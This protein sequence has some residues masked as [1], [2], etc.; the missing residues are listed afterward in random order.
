MQQKLVRNNGEGPKPTAIVSVK[1]RL[2]FAMKKSPLTREQRYQ[3]Q[4]LIKAGHKP[5]AM[6]SLIKKTEQNKSPN[7]KN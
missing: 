1:I 7:G 5:S 6:A 2:F 4:V 3:I